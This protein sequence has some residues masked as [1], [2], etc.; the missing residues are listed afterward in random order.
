MKKTWQR[1]EIHGNNSGTAIAAIF[2][3][4]AESGFVS[5]LAAVFSREH[6]VA[7]LLRLQINRAVSGKILPKNISGGMHRNPGP[8]AY[9]Q[10]AGMPR[11]FFARRHFMLL[12]VL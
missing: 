11:R 12:R 9:G 10:A 1:R 4:R 7:D 2:N 8:A 6:N 3:G 5:G